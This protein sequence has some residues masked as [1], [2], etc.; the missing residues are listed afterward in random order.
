LTVVETVG[1]TIEDVVKL[2]VD[3]LVTVVETAGETIEDVVKPAVDP[4]ITAVEDVAPLIEDTVRDVGSAIDDAVIEPV[5]DVVESIETPDLPEVDLP[6][7]DLPSIDLD[8]D[9]QLPRI[10]MPSATRTTDGLFGKELFRFQTEIGVSPEAP[11]IQ[12]PTRRS[13]QAQQPR[14]QYVD[15][16]DDPFDNPFARKV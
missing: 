15:L 10:A 12:A 11:L 9:L 14:E 8:L 6:S 13:A 16:F 1:E 7:I 3:P 5:K 4:V 2:A